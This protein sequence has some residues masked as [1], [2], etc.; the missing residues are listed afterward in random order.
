MCYSSHVHSKA[1]ICQTR[2][3]LSEGLVMMIAIN[4][5]NAIWQYSIGDL[6]ARRIGET[7]QPIARMVRNW[8]C[9]RMDSDTLRLNWQSFQMIM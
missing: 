8:P 1:I 6:N 3:S 9:N 7:V 5:A 2:L 4:M